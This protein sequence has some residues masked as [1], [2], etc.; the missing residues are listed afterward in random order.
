MMGE[1]ILEATL[2]WIDD[3]KNTV[4]KLDI[5]FHGGEPLTA[6]LDFYHRALPGLRGDL[7]LKYQ[8]LTCRATCGC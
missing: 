3:L 8:K 2:G 1:S 7:K 5:I 4:D 6:G